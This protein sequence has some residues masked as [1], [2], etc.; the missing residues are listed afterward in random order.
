MADQS[1]IAAHSDSL[2]VRFIDND[3]GN[4]VY[5]DIVEATNSHSFERVDGKEVWTGVSPTA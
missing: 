2:A 3:L 5:Y 4:W 1:Y